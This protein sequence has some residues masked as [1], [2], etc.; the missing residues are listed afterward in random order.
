MSLTPPHSFDL[1]QPG[2]RP[3][4]LRCCRLF[5]VSALFAALLGASLATL[6]ADQFGLF[7]YEIIGPSAVITDYPDSEPGHLD[8]PAEIEGI[9]VTEIAGS[10]FDNC[11]F[12]SVTIPATVT[13]IGDRAF[14]STRLR[15]VHLLGSPPVL[16]S[17]PF[18]GSREFSLYYPVDT[19]GYTTPTWEGYPAVPGGRLGTL[20]YRI[21]GN[22]VEI[23]RCHAGG[24][25]NLT[26]PP[27]IEGRPV[28]AI[29]S[30]AFGGCLD[31]A[32][33]SL[34]DSITTI[35]SRTFGG[36]PELTSVSLPTNLTD[37]PVETFFGCSALS[38]LVIP[39]GVTSIGN[40]ACGD[41]TALA[42]LT[43][44]PELKT[45]GDSAFRNCDALT[46]VTIPPSVASIGTGAFA[47]CDALAVIEVHPASPH[48]FSLDGVLFNADQSS[49]LQCPAAK[50]GSYTVPEGVARIAGR[51]FSGC[52][53]LTSIWCQDGVTFVGESAFQSC[54]G[55][56]SLHLSSALTTIYGLAFVGC[57]GL[58]FLAIPPHV[59]YVGYGAFYRCA[60]LH[61]VLFEGD[62]PY[63]SDN[64]TFGCP[65]EVTFYRFKAANGFSAPSWQ[66]YPT[67]EIDPALHPAAPW[68]LSHGCPHTTDLSL[69]LNGDG[70]S[71]LMAYALDLDP[72]RPKLPA[73]I[74]DPSTLSIT[75]Y[76]ARPGVTYLVES[77][78]GL[79]TWS[80]T[81][82]TLS[83]PTS[84]G[85]RTASVD[86]SSPARFLRLSVH[87]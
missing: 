2:Y 39:N 58:T 19:P 15:I 59:T 8:I 45:I 74:L 32:H 6:P 22:A 72:L 61:T 83:N 11:G 12:T 79:E 67:I 28:T 56:T 64:L 53:R 18:S 43:L 47:S 80:T 70:V 41:C 50:Q 87:Q 62:G 20:T 73:P 78:D 5:T 37:I 49:L 86:R 76:G 36:C 14:E 29:A 1:I 57:D 26:V 75:F 63:L 9:P 46:S 82:V 30:W 10:A 35:G 3:N 13:A 69:D 66:P 17:N 55:L 34:P 31:L 48:F 27:I 7:T 84:E 51:A 42:S 68:L 38:Q 81:D 33:L 25:P 85:F 21:I 40:L 71:L 60:A 54:H 4:R 52:T 77:S 24:V 16:G 23:A 65:P 44:P